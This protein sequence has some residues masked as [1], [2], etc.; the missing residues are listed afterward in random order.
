MLC[1]APTNRYDVIWTVRSN[2]HKVVLPNVWCL[3]F[4]NCQLATLYSSCMFWL[5]LKRHFSG[6]IQIASQENRFGICHLGCI[7][8]LVL[9]GKLAE[10]TRFFEPP[11]NHQCV[12]P[13]GRFK[14]KESLR[15]TMTSTNTNND[16]NNVPCSTKQRI[17]QHL[18]LFVQI[19]AWPTKASD[20]LPSAT[21]LK[22]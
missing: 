18:G 5:T 2:K 15:T 7:N 9:L 17:L 16:N 3:G 12:R 11:N 10:R 21:M 8:K 6:N 13:N 4:S 20:P 19:I 1:T 14:L 22:P